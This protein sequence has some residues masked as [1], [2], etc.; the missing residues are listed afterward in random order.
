MGDTAQTLL[1]LLIGAMGLIGSTGAALAVLHRFAWGP[2]V[3]AD[4]RRAEALIA[5]ALKPVVEKLEDI[6]AA[7]TDVQ[8][9]VNH[10]NGK[11]L[12][13]L[14]VQAGRDLAVVTARFDDHINQEK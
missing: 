12:K 10:N 14:V 5:K 13:D 2:F 6:D 11:S 7:V 4:E 8:H 1:T 3:A 9:E